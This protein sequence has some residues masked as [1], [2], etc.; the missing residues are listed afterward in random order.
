[1]ASHQLL[2]YVLTT[3]SDSGR[4]LSEFSNDP[5]NR[6]TVKPPLGGRG[7]PIKGLLHLLH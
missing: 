2:L 3:D 6:G 1:M 4:Q 5:W 7:G